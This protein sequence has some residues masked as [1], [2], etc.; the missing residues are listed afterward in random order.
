MKKMLKR[1]ELTARLMQRQR[2]YHALHL[3]GQI[4]TLRRIAQGQPYV[5]CTY[6]IPA[7]LTALF[8]V[9]FLFIDRTVGLFCALDELPERF[10]TPGCSYQQAFAGLLAAGRIPPPAL[11]L[12]CCYPCEGAE[13]M[14]REI[15][16]TWHVPLVRLRPAHF[17]RDVI[18]A[19]RVL[20]ERFPRARTAEQVCALSHLARQEKEDIDRLRIQYPGLLPS[21]EFLKLFPVE[22]D[23]GTEHAAQVLACLKKSMMDRL[24]QYRPQ[25]RLRIFWMGLIPLYD[26]GLL[27]R[28]EQE[29]PVQFVFEEMWMFERPD[30]SDGLS[31]GLCRGL[32]CSFF[33][34]F[35]RRMQMILRRA[36][37]LQ[38]GLIVQLCQKHC[39]FLPPFTPQVRSWCERAAMPFA[40]VTCDVV[41]RDKEEYDTTLRQ[42]IERRLSQL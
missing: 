5:L 39:A 18:R 32:E 16:R 2:P 41:Y 20:A 9:P 40:E 11:I 25:E 38:C 17:A 4:E 26:N 37:E 30:L 35:E 24:A 33:F 29:L 23:F 31:C 13:R 6:S 36:Q 10:W 15:A 27:E 34:R 21:G 42:L 19:G 7:E 28:L 3:T 14:C 12:S 8:D 1:L 22:N